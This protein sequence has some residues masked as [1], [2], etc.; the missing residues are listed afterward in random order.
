MEMQFNQSDICKILIG[1]EAN[2]AFKKK[3]KKILLKKKLK[4]KPILEDPKLGINCGG[5]V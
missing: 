4:P 5:C 1:K 3:K 2:Q